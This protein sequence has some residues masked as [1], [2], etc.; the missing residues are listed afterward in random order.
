[1][2]VQKD[3]KEDMKASMKAKDGERL[4]AVKAMRAAIS[5]KEVDERCEVNDA[6]TVDIFTKM[7][8]QR[9]ESVASYKLAGRPELVMAEENEI[10]V[11]MEYM[12]AQLSDAEV[13]IIINEAIEATRAASIKDMGKVMAIVKPKTAGKADAGALGKKIKTLLNDKADFKS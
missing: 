7:V 12:P 5:Q 11:I 6:M 3:L 1:M 8:K 9:R 4:T 13:E 2:G 10:A